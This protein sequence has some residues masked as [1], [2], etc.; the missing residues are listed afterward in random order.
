M[1]NRAIITPE[2]LK[3]ARESARISE[4]TAAS[5]IKVT[6]DKLQ[7]WESGIDFPTINQ[8]K[9]LARLY[10][11]PFA[12][13]FLPEIPKDFQILQDFRKSGS[14]DLS[15]TSIFMIRDIQQKQAWIRDLFVDNNA[16]KL[17]F[18]GKF[19]VNDNPQIV[20]Q[21]IIKELNINPLNYSYKSPLLEW[22]NKTESKGIFISRASLINSKLILDV[23]ELQGFSISDEYAPFIFINSKDWNSPQL[24]TLVHEIAH[25]WIAQTG[26]SNSNEPFYKDFDQYNPI[27]IFCNEVAAN[28]LMPSNVLNDLNSSFFKDYNEIYKFSKKLGVSTFALIIRALKLNLITMR[29]FN[30]LK[31]IAD[32]EFDKFNKKAC[33]LKLKNKDKYSG[34]NYFLLLI[35]RNSKLF[36]QNVLDAF[37]SGAIE[38]TLASNLLNTH[39]NKFSILE[40]QM[41]K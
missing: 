18:I 23:D 14:K 2:V 34:P 26:I 29:T 20:A 40:S 3:W 38:A 30:Q 19:S 15:S 31:K 5:K 25:L 36:T 16:D 21:N 9:S 32:F 37:R 17:S 13:F 6:I 1:T 7:K 4:E 10:R 27:E 8:A 28:A 22:I 11:R 39:V 41:L 12:I 35:N 33:E 24:F